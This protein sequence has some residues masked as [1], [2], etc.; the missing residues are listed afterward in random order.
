MTSN[1]N[2]FFFTHEFVGQLGSSAQLK[3]LLF[4]VG[5]SRVW[6]GSTLLLMSR[7]PAD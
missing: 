7:P 3:G 2:C 1:N 6:G 4:Y 5:F